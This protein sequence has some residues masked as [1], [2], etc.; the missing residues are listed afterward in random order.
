MNSSKNNDS[1]NNKSID[2]MKFVP[3]NLPLQNT[4]NGNVTGWIPILFTNNSSSKQNKNTNSLNNT[5]EKQTP[6]NLNNYPDDTSVE[7]LYSYNSSSSITSSAPSNTPPDK[8]MREFM[9]NLDED[10]DLIRNNNDESINNIY[11][12]FEENNSN[13]ISMLQAYKVPEPLIKMMI[14][15]IIEISINDCKKE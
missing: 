5:I 2:D 11:N 6:N 3:F 1:Y 4:P 15:K 14:R 13:I 12:N 9:R 7:N 8:I 10:K